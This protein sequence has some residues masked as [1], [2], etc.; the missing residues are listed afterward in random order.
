[1]SVNTRIYGGGGI[2]FG[3]QPAIDDLIAA[4]YSAV[5]VWSVHVATD[6]T[7]SLN[8]TQIVAI[9]VASL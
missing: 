3:G 2:T 9:G 5:L 6:G 4:G 8:N 1:M 7:L